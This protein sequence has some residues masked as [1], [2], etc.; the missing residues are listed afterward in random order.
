MNTWRIR[1]RLFLLM[2]FASTV[3]ACS[4]AEAPTT[5]ATGTATGTATNASSA[6]QVKVGAVW[7]L[8]G[9]AAAYG[10]PQK[11]ATELAVEEIN[12]KKLLGDRQLVVQIEDDAGDKQQAIAVFDKLINQD[13][14]AAILG[15]TLSNSAKA[16][17]PQAQ[18]A[19]IPVL[20]ASNTASGIVEIG[21]FI[22]RASLPESVVIPNTIKTTQAALGYKKVAV[23][24]GDDDVFTKSGYDVFRK[25]LT[26]QGIEVL[27]TETFKKG[28]TDFAPQLT[29]IKGLN[30]DAIIVSA[31]AEEGANIMVQARQL[32]IP[33][34]VPF[35]GGNGFNSPKLAEIAGPAANGAISGAAWFV[36][37]TT[38]G[39]SEF[40]QAFK[41]KYGSEPDQFAAQAYAAVYIL[42]NAI[43]TADSADPK[44]IQAALAQ[45]KDL[46]TVLGKFSFDEQGD[47]LYAPVVQAMK[48]G[49]FT[50]FG[51]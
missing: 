11:Q 27:T 23:L 50:L 32:G 36:G 3:A 33:E 16:A 47:C 8:S 28:D 13:K 1:R 18:A 25:T 26:D 37:S 48:D 2:L 24:Y 46:D 17:D 22:F 51:S 12:A 15:P 7:S 5:S 40:V 20:A 38:P 45:T 39:N 30:P 21:D 41:A 14:V 49:Q 10:S 44:A 34:T 6:A 35:I 19:G 29:K 4:T 9:G 43:K 31:L 42:A